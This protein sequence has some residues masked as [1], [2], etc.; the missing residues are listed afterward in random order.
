M[1]AVIRY[2]QGVTLLFPYAS[3]KIIL[4]DTL[5]FNDTIKSDTKVFTNICTWMSSNYKRGKFLSGIF[6]LHRITIVR[7]DG[8]SLKNLKMLQKMCDPDA[9]QNVF[10]TTTQCS[11]VN[12]ALGEAH[13]GNLRHEGFWAG[14]ISQGASLERFMDTRESGLDLI[15]KL[16]EKEPKPLYTQDEMEVKGMALVETEV[17]KFM[18]EELISL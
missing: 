4:V 1:L 2:C 14:L 7:I 8:S 15:T 10:L 9:L 17:G 3:I 12:P 13:E 5:G 6:Y 18:S 11:K 16:I